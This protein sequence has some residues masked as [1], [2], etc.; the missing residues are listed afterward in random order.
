[1]MDPEDSLE[2]RNPL[3]FQDAPSKEFQDLIVMGILK[4]LS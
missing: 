3:C 2:V 4:V 1:M